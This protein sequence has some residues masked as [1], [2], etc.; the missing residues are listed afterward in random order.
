MTEHT[1]IERLEIL[2]SA[3][4]EHLKRPSI[5]HIEENLLREAIAALKAQSWTPIDDPIVETWKDGRRLLVLWQC[6]KVGL[7][8][9]DYAYFC[10]K[11]QD[12]WSLE[13]GSLSGEKITAVML[14][15]PTR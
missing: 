5:I 13:Y 6:G 9:P 7:F 3:P 11:I 14:P 2:D 10:Y 15:P 4:R 8:E 12:W 1:L